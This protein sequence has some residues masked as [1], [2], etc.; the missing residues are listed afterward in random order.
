MGVSFVVQTASS[1]SHNN[2]FDHINS[3]SCDVFKVILITCLLTCFECNPRVLIAAFLLVRGKTRST[4]GS[5]IC[6]ISASILSWGRLE[7]HRASF[8]VQ[9]GLIPCGSYLLITWC[10]C[11]LTGCV[12]HCQFLSI[13]SRISQLNDSSSKLL[14]NRPSRNSVSEVPQGAFDLVISYFI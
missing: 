1:S 2:L 10:L 9:L 13:Q 14:S 4:V 11:G 5:P 12:P 8:E 6:T 3:P 7:S